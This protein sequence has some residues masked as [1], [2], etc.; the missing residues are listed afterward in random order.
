MKID[1]ITLFPGMFQGPFDESIIGRARKQGVVDIQLVNLRDFAHDK[2]GTVDDSP[3]GGGAGMVLKPE[4]LFEAVEALKTPAARVILLTPQGRCFRQGIA[5]DLAGFEHLILICGHYEGVDERVR[6]ALVDDELSIGDYVL[7]NG[8]LA[9][10]VVTDAVVRLLPGAL[11][12]E[13]SAASDSFGCE[14]QLDYPQYTRP[15]EFRGMQVPDVLL[16]GD[17]QQIE[18]W[19]REQARIRTIARR[20]ELLTTMDGDE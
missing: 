8:N 12:S 16:S 2:R 19:R 17:H 20:P 6:Q 18:N 9:A 14:A 1:I 7:T 4:V 11:G 3:F 10:L 15:A 13:G 5:R